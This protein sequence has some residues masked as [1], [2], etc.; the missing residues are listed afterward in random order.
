MLARLQEGHH[1]GMPDPR[2]RLGLQ[3]EP[4]AL[5]ERRPAPGQEQLQRHRPASRVERPVHGA[6]APARDLLHQLRP[7][8]ERIRAFVKSL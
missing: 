6:H 7:A 3:R 5:D 4:L 8:A 2:Q 1:P